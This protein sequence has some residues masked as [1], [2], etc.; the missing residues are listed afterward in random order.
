[1]DLNIRRD[2]RRKIK[3]FLVWAAL[4]PVCECSCL[5]SF[6]I[7]VCRECLDFLITSHG[8]RLITAADPPDFAQLQ[9]TP[10]FRSKTR[11]LYVRILSPL[12]FGGVF[13]MC[14]FSNHNTKKSA[15]A[16]ASIRD[17]VHPSA[18]M[19]LALQQGILGPAASTTACSCK[20][21]NTLKG[22]FFFYYQTIELGKIA[23]PQ[24]DEEKIGKKKRK[25]R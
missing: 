14:G 12:L 8:Q 2:K 22:F 25:W 21:R 3:H 16:F 13:C 9:T 18:L 11:S 6:F 1:M 19:K 4:V 24:R 20:N 7:R 15:T 5:F 17:G 10:V 23:R